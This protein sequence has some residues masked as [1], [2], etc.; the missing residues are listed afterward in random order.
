MYVGPA[1]SFC[2]YWAPATNLELSTQVVHFLSQKEALVV[3]FTRIFALI[4]G[5]SAYSGRRTSTSSAK[6][7]LHRETL[8]QRLHQNEIGV[9]RDNSKTHFP[10]SSLFSDLVSF[11][12]D[13]L[14]LDAIPP[15]CLKCM[16][17]CRQ[18]L[19]EVFLNTA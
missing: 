10:S 15:H 17:G 13:S 12:L 19:Q 3:S 11:V 7:R 18:V 4:V 5:N 14:S 16:T 6:S 8:E 2:L 9:S 1:T